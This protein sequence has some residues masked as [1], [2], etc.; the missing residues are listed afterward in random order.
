MS[1]RVYEIDIENENNRNVFF[2]PIQQVLRG[3]MDPRKGKDPAVRSLD[4]RWPNGIPGVRL[5]INIRDKTAWIHDRL[6][7]EEHK[8]TRELIE[9]RKMRLGPKRES[10]TDVHVA[11]P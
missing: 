8:A 9:R 10:F 6:Y 1:E 11:S 2:P 3:T 4:S 7:D 5:G